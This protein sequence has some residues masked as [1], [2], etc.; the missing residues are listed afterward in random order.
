MPARGRG[1]RPARGRRSAAVAAWRGTRC[2]AA[3]CGGSAPRRRRRR[4]ARRAAGR[5][6]GRGVADRVDAAEARCGARRAG[7]TADRSRCRRGRA[8]AAR[9]RVTIPSCAVA[10]ARDR[11][12]QRQATA[13]RGGG[14]TFAS[15]SAAE[16]PGGRGRRVRVDVGGGSGACRHRAARRRAGP[17]DDAELVRLRRDPFTVQG[18]H[19]R[20]AGAEDAAHDRPAL[21]AEGVGRLRVGEAGD[22]GGDEDVA[23]DLRQGADRGQDLG[24]L[25]AQRRVVALAAAQL[26]R[27]VELDAG[28]AAARPR[29]GGRCGGGASRRACSA[30]RSRP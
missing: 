12:H 20:L 18:L 28:D 8:R 13:R 9:P 21:A 19:E 25:G 5:G 15:L 30:A 2:A 17:A 11:R 24:L 6:G 26:G 1:R 10:S 27:G 22:V 4:A 7:A 16:R 14:L 29:G 3:P 23:V